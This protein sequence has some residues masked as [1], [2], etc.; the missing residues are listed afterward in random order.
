MSRQNSQ[1]EITNSNQVL[2][3]NNNNK[4]TFG[5]RAADNNNTISS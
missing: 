3:I 4:S 1:I 2:K 5:L